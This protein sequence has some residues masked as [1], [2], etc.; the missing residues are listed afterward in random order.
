MAPAAL[1]IATSGRSDVG[2]RLI[3]CN[4][5]THRRSA[6][7][8]DDVSLAHRMLWELPLVV[9]LKR[10]IVEEQR[11]LVA[12]RVATAAARRTTATTTTSGGGRAEGVSNDYLCWP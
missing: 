6:N 12:S 4:N 3:S 5:Y 2:S 10:G 11:P 1:L 7:D 9:V 8:Y